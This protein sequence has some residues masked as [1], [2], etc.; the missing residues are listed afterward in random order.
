MFSV[1]KPNRHGH[2]LSKEHAMNKLIVG[3]MLLAF[4]ITAAGCTKQRSAAAKPYS[5][6][7]PAAARTIGHKSTT[8]VAHKTIKPVTTTTPAQSKVTKPEGTKSATTMP[9][10]AKPEAQPAGG[11]ETKAP[12][13]SASPKEQK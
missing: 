6:A 9:E 12:A 1:G 13:T 4:V 8:S 3:A 10:A 5:K 2:S 7:E 11:T